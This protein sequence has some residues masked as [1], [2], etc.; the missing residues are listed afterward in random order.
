MNILFASATFA[1][2]FFILQAFLIIHLIPQ[3]FFIRYWSGPFDISPLWFS[4]VLLF[5]TFLVRYPCYLAVKYCRPS[6]TWAL[7]TNHTLF[8]YC[9]FSVS[10]PLILSIICVFLPHCIL[11]VIQ[12]IP[13]SRRAVVQIVIH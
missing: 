13:F 6:K 3:Y 11:L 12:N 7:N 8:V 2:S 9:S 5:C 1:S 10:H 4:F